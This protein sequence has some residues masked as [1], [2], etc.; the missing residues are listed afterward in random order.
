[1]FTFNSKISNYIKVKKF[2]IERLSVEQIVSMAKINTPMLQCSIPHKNIIIIYSYMF[3]NMYKNVLTF[4]F[5]KR[6][7][8]R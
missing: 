3:I 1:M 8:T 4:I 5:K 7:Y 6:E 2:T